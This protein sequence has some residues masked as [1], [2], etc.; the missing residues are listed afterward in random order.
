M[1]Y[2]I[3]GIICGLL[4]TVS[5]C[6]KNKDEATDNNESLF[7]EGFWAIKDGAEFSYLALLPNDTFLYAENDLS[8]NSNKENGLELGTYIYDAKKEEIKF[9]IEYDDNDPGNDSGVGDIGSLLSYKA[10]LLEE[11][12]KLSLLNGELVFDKIELTAS[13]PVVGVWSAKYGSEFSYLALLPNNTFLYAEYVSLVR[14]DRENGLEVGTYVYDSNKEEIVFD[15]E[16]DDNDPGNN[17]GVGDIGT[18]AK[19]SVQLSNN[20]NTLTIAGLVLA[21]S[22]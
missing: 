13:S 18:P 4:I 17:S 6:S 3:F 2:K 14:S 9:N 1:K 16:Y 11:S 12:T 19:L 21:M 7:V 10:S 5:S 22:L 8:V 20:N 15:I